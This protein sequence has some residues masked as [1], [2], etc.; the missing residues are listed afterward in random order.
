M[1]NELLEKEKNTLL[2]EK[3]TKTAPHTQT[4]SLVFSK[5]TTYNHLQE[6]QSQN[7]G[8]FYPLERWNMRAREKI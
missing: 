6:N 8:S 5:P 7:Q 1:Q 4:K 3:K 2:L